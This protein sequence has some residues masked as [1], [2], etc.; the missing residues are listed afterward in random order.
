MKPQY[1]INLLGALAAMMCL[2]ACQAPKEE[3]AQ[4][5]PSLHEKILTLDTHVD[6]PLTYMT[7]IDPSGATDLQVDFSKL[8]AGGLDAAFFIIYTPQ[9]EET[10]LGY[11]EA[12][13]IA[14]TRMSAIEAMLKAYPDDITLV[15]RADD[16]AQI[17]QSGKIAALIGMENAFPL[18]ADI[19]SVHDWAARGVRYV[20][21]SLIHI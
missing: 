13:Q 8:R 21:L 16:T 18:A 14:A 7:E 4:T 10:K 1:F 9:G 12:E 2:A 3:A 5:P 19:D 15:R 17:N 20:G 6:I 11:A